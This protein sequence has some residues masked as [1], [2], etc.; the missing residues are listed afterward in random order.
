MLKVAAKAEKLHK[1]VKKVPFSVQCWCTKFM[2][3]KFSAE[4][5]TPIMGVTREV[6]GDKV[7]Y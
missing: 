7:L 3:V 5:R 2:Q 4:S 6:T 1:R